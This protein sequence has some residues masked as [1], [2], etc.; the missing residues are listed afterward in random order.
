MNEG[1]DTGSSLQG[2]IPNKVHSIDD[3]RQQVQVYLLLLSI[4]YLICSF[5]FQYM[6]MMKTEDYMLQ[7]SGVKMKKIDTDDI[8]TEKVSCG[9][10]PPWLKVDAE[11]SKNFAQP[12]RLSPRVNTCADWLKLCDA[13]ILYANI[14]CSNVGS[15]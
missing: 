12:I 3:N 13:I 4:F 5:S 7:Y 15:Y 8:T 2:M 11:E 1:Q 14:F 9:V 6:K 10:Q